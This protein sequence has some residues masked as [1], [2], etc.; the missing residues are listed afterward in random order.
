M[1]LKLFKHIKKKNKKISKN[2]L[3]NNKKYAIIN[4][5]I[6]KRGKIKKWQKLTNAKGTEL[7]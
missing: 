2:P 7:F 1:C 5:E 3:T 4:T 6:K